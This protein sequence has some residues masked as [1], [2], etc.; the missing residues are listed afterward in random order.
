MKKIFL[1]SLLLILSFTIFAQSKSQLGIRIGANNAK[2]LHSQLDSKTGLYAGLFLAVRLTDSYTLQP[3]IAYSNQGGK[4]SIRNGENLNINY[5]SIG[6]A[7]KFFVS[8][9]QGFHF[10]LGP[11]LDVNFDDNFINLINDNDNSLEITPIDLALFGGIG[12]EFDFGLALELRFKQGLIDL[13]FN[14]SGEYGGNSEENQ[15]NRV[16]QIGLAYKFN[17]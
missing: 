7:N 14:D 1:L 6:L 17:M 15:L 9:H 12:Y 16:I 4:A 10:I 3:E 11:S 2:V 5:V 8:P 13:D